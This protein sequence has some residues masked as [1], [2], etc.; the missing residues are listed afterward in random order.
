MALLH[1]AAEMLVY[2]SCVVSVTSSVSMTTV[3]PTISF[4]ISSEVFSYCHVH[5]INLL[6][7]NT[8]VINNMK[9]VL[10]HSKVHKT[11]G[12]INKVCVNVYLPEW[13]TK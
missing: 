6:G 9:T 11:N 12:N 13:R 4:L 2:C 5:N 8:S 7:E 1:T 3:V 10:L